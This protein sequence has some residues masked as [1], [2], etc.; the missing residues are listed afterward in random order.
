M[1]ELPTPVKFSSLV[2]LGVALGYNFINA[3]V[4]AEQSLIE[5]RNGVTAR[6]GINGHVN[7]KSEWEAVKYGASDNSLKRLWDSMT[8][9]F[10]IA[11]NIMPWIVLK[12][13]PAPR[14]RED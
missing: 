6:K 11:E 7:L 8:W 13:T 5:Y 10:S 14:R 4:D 1:K 9:P 3:Y 12:L 2:Y